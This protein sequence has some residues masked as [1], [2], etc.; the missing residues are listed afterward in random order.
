MNR[1][2]ALGLFLALACCGLPAA[3]AQDATPNPPGLSLE[4]GVTVTGMFGPDAQSLIYSFSAQAGDIVSMTMR[5]DQIDSYL[6]LDDARGN[7]LLSD[8]DSANDLDAR[9][10]PLRLPEDGVYL[11]VAS[12]FD[13]VV[14]DG[15]DTALG[16]FTL[17]L[18]DHEP[19]EISYPSTVKATLEDGETLHLYAFEATRG[20]VLSLALNA[21]AFNPLL[22]LTDTHNISKPPLRDDDSGPDKNAHI[23]PYI[24]P[25]SGPY[26]LTAVSADEATGGDYVL[27][28]AP[29]ESERIA[30]GERVDVTLARD[31]TPAAV[32]SFEA[33]AGDVVDIRVES[34]TELDTTL[35]LIGPDGA[36][37]A[38]NDD[39]SGRDPALIARALSEAGTYTFVVQP[40]TR[41][42]GGDI[43]V[44]LAQSTGE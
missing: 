34:P 33:A 21:D 25:E 27:S 19:D 23:V 1:L 40:F 44:E 15:F 17:T 7:A 32:F 11:V 31:E 28:I 18:M 22:A 29:L 26:L 41:G 35:T 38:D 6:R 42:F 5:S 43:T 16:D 4:P 10:G 20:D 8:D 13:Y 3:A 2:R 36:Q 30:Y 9:I 14:S 24:V 12:T 39:A 37:V